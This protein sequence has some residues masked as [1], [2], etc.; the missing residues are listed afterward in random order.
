MLNNFFRKNKNI[1]LRKN[2]FNTF[3]KVPFEIYDSKNDYISPLRSDIKRFLSLKNPLFKNL[4]DFEYWSLLRDGR[5]VGRI[6]CHIHHASNIKFGWKNSYFGFFDCE[7]NYES[8]QILLSKAEDFCRRNSCN[9]VMGNFNLTAMQQIGV[10]THI[11]RSGSYTDQ[12]YNPT[13]ISDLLLNQGFSP[14]FPMKT[15]EMDLDSF[16]P[17]SLLS[18]KQEKILNDSKYKFVDLKTQ[19]LDKNLESMRECLNM[20][21]VENPFFV[22]LTKD[23][24]WFQAKDMMYIIDRRISSIVEENGVPV[25]AIICIP[26]LNPL[27]KK[28]GS[29]FHFSSVYHYIKHRLFCNSAVIIYYSVKK[30]HHDLGINGAMLYKTISALKKYGYKKLGGTWISDSNSASIRQI[31]KLGGNIMHEL[32]LFSKKIEPSL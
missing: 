24:M 12:A 32:S 10:V 9:Q 25:G 29:E 28:M 4:N 11:Y 27:L 30:S 13:Y 23:E 2:D 17:E 5:P 31:E 1:E 26:N 18:E 14:F 8:S 6:V 3:F 22:P 7:N 16:T 19:S 21:F 20:G 15:Y